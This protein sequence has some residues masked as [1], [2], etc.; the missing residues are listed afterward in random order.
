MTINLNWP[1]N[2]NN[3]VV[4]HCNLLTTNQMRVI[5][6]FSATKGV[7]K[8]SKLLFHV[9]VGSENPTRACFP[10]LQAVANQ[11]RGDDVKIALGGDAVVLMLDSIINSVVPVCWTSLK[12]TFAKVVEYGIPIYV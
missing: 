9:M 10:F 12:E 3:K 5:L 1:M 2:R 7:K 4:F 8:N 11:E 6:L